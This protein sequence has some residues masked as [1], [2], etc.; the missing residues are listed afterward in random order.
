MSRIV[1]TSDLHLGITKASTIR[2]LVSAI[3]ALEPALTVLAGDIGEGL[4]NFVECLKLFDPLPG[5]I[6]VLAGNHDVWAR[7]STS[8]QD[9]WERRLPEAVQTAGMLWL[10]DTVWQCRDLA[11]VGSLAWYDYSAADPTFLSH[12]ATFFSERK[13]FYN[14]DAKYVCWPWSDQEFATRLGDKLC[15]RLKGLEADPR[16]GR[17]LVVSHVPLFEE[18]MCRK[19]QDLH[20]G[21]SNAYFGNLTLGER[22][23]EMS[24]VQAVVS[25]HTHIGRE[26]Q[27]KRPGFPKERALAVSVLGSDYH[28]PMYSVIDSVTLSG[29]SG[30]TQN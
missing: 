12:P 7:G 8:S 29:F 1:I 18:Q 3:E 30:R 17:V 24:K 13:R 16:V 11:V 23:L 26:G 28:A 4:P 27:V 21:L 9:I 22:V 6:A 15:E 5:D 10:E 14:L 19:P 25:G 20:W 2:T